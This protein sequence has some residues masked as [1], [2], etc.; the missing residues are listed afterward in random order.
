MFSGCTSNSQRRAPPDYLKRNG[1]SS[2][3]SQEWQHVP[4]T[5]A[6]TIGIYPE[7]G[8]W[9]GFEISTGEGVRTRV[10]VVSPVQKDFLSVLRP[11]WAGIIR[12][13]RRMETCRNGLD[14]FRHSVF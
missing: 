9:H 2:L 5:I 11:L 12:R 3:R 14:A 1:T 6:L 13:M 10:S 7:C 8:M 4:F